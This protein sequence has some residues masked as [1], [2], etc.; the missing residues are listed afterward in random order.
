LRHTY[1]ERKREQILV[2]ALLA[3]QV[4]IMGITYRLIRARRLRNC[5]RSKAASLSLLSA[6]LSP[7]LNPIEEEAFSKIKG[8]SC[9][10]LKLAVGRLYSRGIGQAL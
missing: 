1:I 9:E 8:I 3:G 4:V 2:P 7:G 6:L 5:S 10:R